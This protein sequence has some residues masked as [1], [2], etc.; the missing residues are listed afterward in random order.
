MPLRML[1][2][3]SVLYRSIV[4]EDLIYKGNEIDL[5]APRFFVFY[6]GRE[7]IPE[8]SILDFTLDVSVACMLM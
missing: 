5:P 2:Y 7:T 6:N 1:F 4:P 3:L 8:R